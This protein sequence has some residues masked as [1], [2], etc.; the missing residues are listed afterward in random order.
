LLRLGSQ[1][2]VQ[3][4]P[5][6]LANSPLLSCSSARARCGLP[7]LGESGHVK[8][9]GCFGTCPACANPSK[10]HNGQSSREW[11]I[12][13]VADGGFRSTI[14]MRRH[15]CDDSGIVFSGSHNGFLG[16]ANAVKVVKRGCLSIDHGRPILLV[17]FC[18]DPNGWP[19]VRRGRVCRWP[20]LR[21]TE[22]DSFSRIRLAPKVSGA[23]QRRE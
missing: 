4:L 15:P 9:R 5:L 19:D 20:L 3:G 17:P 1:P 10:G 18:V 11:L 22:T 8:P 12:T 13:P 7:R 2:I 14:A 6:L 16:R 23:E 21:A